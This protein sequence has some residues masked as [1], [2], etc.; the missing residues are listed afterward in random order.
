MTA[1]EETWARVEGPWDLVVVGGGITGAGLLREAVRAGLKALLLERRDF[2]WGTSSRSSK[3][4]HGGLRYLAQGRL[5]LVRDS[6]RER[7]RLL[8]EAPGLVT[9]LG[10]LLPTYR[11]GRP[12]RAALG[13][14]LLLYDALGATWRHARFDAAETA[15][16][17]PHLSRVGLTGAF[18]YEDA[19]TDD[20]RLVLRLL[21]EATA[22][23]GAALNYAPVSGLLR[24]ARGRVAGVAVSDGGVTKEVRARAVVNATGAWGDALR[25][26]V[27]ARPRIRRLRGSHLVFPAW[28]FPAPEAIT[29]AHSED[30]RP[31]F[32]VPWQ[33]VT[34][35]GTTDLDEAGSPDAEPSIS[36]AEVA[37]LEAALAARFPD[38]GLSSKD[39]IASTCGI[40]PV[41]ASGKK[42]PSAESREHAVLEESGLVTVM[43]GKLTTFRLVAGEA[44]SRLSSLFPSLATP[45]SGRVLDEVP[46]PP[47]LVALGRRRARR[48]LG[49]YGA[50]AE[51]VAE[52]AVDGELTEIPGTDILWAELRFA[53][54]AE[55]VLHLDDL[56]LRR[57]RLGLLVEEGAA[58]HLPRIRE[59]CQG[60]LAWDD[61]RWNE[62]ETAYRAEIARAWSVP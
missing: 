12:S 61:A 60:E 30:R 17:A 54:R 25:A 58:R 27:G 37:Y 31:L 20:A 9:P 22:A 36:R 41:I 33:G 21:R 15:R 23:G 1:R 16:R 46:E 38:L 59:I 34:L 11:G 39:A 53:A 14:G 10:F 57:V 48:L 44:L 18:R 56:L 32:V 50:D 8:A 29:V 43:G 4:V 6:V 26:E 28:R 47:A 49:R 62:E 7:E 55:G 42:S 19:S 40:R 13:L 24:D 51:A 3:L 5:G 52:C 2:A 45:T 35:F